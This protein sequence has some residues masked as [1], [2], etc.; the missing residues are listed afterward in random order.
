MGNSALWFRCLLV[1]GALTLAVSAPAVA[2]WAFSSWGDLIVFYPGDAERLIVRTTFGLL[3]SNDG[4]RHFDWICEA[5][6][7]LED[8]EDPMIAITARG[9]GGRRDRRWSGGR[10]PERMRISGRVAALDGEYPRSDPH[11]RSR[12]ILRAFSHFA[13]AP[14][15][16]ASTRSYLLRTTRA[17]PS[18]PSAGGSTASSCRSVSISPRANRAGST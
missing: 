8:Q 4:G 3:V 7:E 15:R 14:R 13:C 17:R 9:V 16:T 18:R 5:A 10:R 11:P 12:G 1:T 6:L 2:E